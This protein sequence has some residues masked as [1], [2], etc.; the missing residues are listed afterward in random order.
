MLL[1]GSRRSTGQASPRRHFRYAF[2][3]EAGLWSLALA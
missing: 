1:P 3:S 2:A